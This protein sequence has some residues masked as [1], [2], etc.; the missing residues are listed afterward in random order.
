MPIKCQES[1]PAKQATK[2]D[3]AIQDAEKKIRSLRESIAVFR[4]RKASGD[5]WPEVI[6][7]K[8]A[9]GVFVQDV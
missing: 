3:E 6:K 4:A 5:K 7:K 9:R 8:R 1:S 2:W